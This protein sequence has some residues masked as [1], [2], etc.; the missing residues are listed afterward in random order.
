MLSCKP[1]IF[2]LSSNFSSLSQH[3]ASLLVQLHVPLSF[4]SASSLIE[5]AFP[6]QVHFN[7]GRL[8]SPFCMVHSRIKMRV[9]YFLVLLSFKKLSQNRR[10]N[11]FG[12]LPN[13]AIFR[14]PLSLFQK[15]KSSIAWRI[16]NWIL[17]WKKDSKPIAVIDFFLCA[18]SRFPPMLPCQGKTS[19]ERADLSNF[20]RH[21]VYFGG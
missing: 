21:D 5:P 11:F 20:H 12:S 19:Y 18:S 3:L 14:P 9:Y 15:D 17:P 1:P 10:S 13:E 7:Y 4:L 6:C 8:L 2:S 16:T